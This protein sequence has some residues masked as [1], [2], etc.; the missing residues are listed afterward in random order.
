MFKNLNPEALG[1]SSRDS[2][3]IELVLSNGFKGLDL[4]LVEFAAQVQAQGPAKAARLITS[5]RLKIGSCELPVDLGA[6]ETDYKAQLERLP[7]LVENVAPLGCTRATYTIEAGSD[8]RPYHENFEFHRRRLAEVAD[9]LAKHR[10]RLGVGFFAPLACRRDKAFTFMQSF[11]E[12][13]L[14][15]RSVGHAGV[16]IALD[17]WHWHLGGGKLDALK[18]L[19]ADSIVTVALSDAQPGDNAQ[20]IELAARRLPGDGGAIDNAALL[21]ALAEA[22][23]DGPVTPLAGQAALS[24]LSRAQIVKQ[25]AAGLDAAWKAAGL[26]AAGKLATVPGR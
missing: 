10:I 20:A 23:Y 5:A 13:L 21:A 11:D 9:R 24:G 8:A 16:G 22:R 19:P 15:L 12:L 2:E 1:I 6:D 14:L 7:A 18:A 25:A 26:N 3:I 17:T 4:N